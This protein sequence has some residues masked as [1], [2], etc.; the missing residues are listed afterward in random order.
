MKYVR[1]Y[2][3]FKSQKDQKPVNEEFLGGLIGKLIGKIKERINKTK[4]VKKWRL[5]I[6]NG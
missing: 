5:Y 1:N 6:R 4:G 3:S 2:E